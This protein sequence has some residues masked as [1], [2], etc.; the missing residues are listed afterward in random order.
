MA[1]AVAHGLS[2]FSSYQCAV[3]AKAVFSV[4]VAVTHAVTVTTIAVAIAVVVTTTAVA[5]L[6]AKENLGL[7]GVYLFLCENKIL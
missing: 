4:A 2:S 7:S 6:T 3:A 1:T 5:S